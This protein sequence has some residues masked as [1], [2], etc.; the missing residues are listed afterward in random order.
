MGMA[1]RPL[2]KSGIEASA[3]GFGCWAIGGPFTMLG[4][5]DG[6]GDVDDLESIDA[7]HLAMDLGVTLFDTADAYGTGHSEE[8]LGKALRGRR[9]RAVVAT[10]GGF[11]HDAQR[12][13]IG[14]ASCRE[15]V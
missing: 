11:V 1:N 3:L 10:K 15:R 8:V 9:G 13:E 2:G 5:P 4:Q 12:R 6:W 14:R 7:I